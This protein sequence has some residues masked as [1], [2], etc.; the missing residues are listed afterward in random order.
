MTID[1]LFF[2]MLR[3]VTHTDKTQVQTAAESTIATLF[4]QLCEEY[5]GLNKYEKIIRFAVNGEYRNS[6]YKMQN[7]D[8]VALI[9]PISG[10]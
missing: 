3:D 7:N 8:E 9:P 10:G 5:H 1:V 6:Q 4:S 2:A